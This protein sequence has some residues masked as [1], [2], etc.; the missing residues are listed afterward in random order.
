MDE[1]F[2]FQGKRAKAEELEVTGVS[3]SGRVRKKSSKLTDFESLDDL[4]ARA[5]KKDKETLPTTSRPAKKEKVK[6]EE[7]FSEEELNHPPYATKQEGF[8]EESDLDVYQQNEESSLESLDS[9]MDDIEEA[10]IEEEVE[11]FQQI[12]GESLDEGQNQSIFLLNKG[13]KKK[14]VIKDGKI[15][16]K[17]TK[18]EKANSRCTPYM[19]WAKEIRQELM[20]SNPDLDFSQTSKKLGELWAT[21]PFHEKYIWKRRAKRLAERSTAAKAGP[22][23]GGG[24]ES[25]K[26][27]S[28]PARKFINK[29]NVSSPTSQNT[30]IIQ[31]A[32]PTE[33]KGPKA[34]VESNVF[35]PVGTTPLDVA[36]HLRLL[37]ESLTIIGE[38]LTE[39]EGQIT[40]SGSFSVL[41]DSLLCALGPLMCLTQQ[42][43]QLNVIPQE[44]LSQLMDNIAY[45]MPGL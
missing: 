38:R 13:N 40:V 39:H 42:V 10:E 17:K 41:L 37:G 12:G 32:S 31:N 15:L 33:A 34:V 6:Q 19:L 45:I 18:K 43:P 4:E 30:T 1:A 22:G 29:Q 7:M 8:S 23:G 5:R 11:G 27:K 26:M 3:R 16:G 9:E 44:Q 21:V 36:A 28:P 2:D 14:L 20:R 24:V 25:K 35:K